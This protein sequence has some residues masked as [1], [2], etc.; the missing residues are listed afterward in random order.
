MTTDCQ[1]QDQGPRP[2]T[3]LVTWLTWSRLETRITIFYIIIII[4]IIIITDLY[5]TFRSEDTEVAYVM[6]G[7][8]NES[9]VSFHLCD[10]I[11]IIK[12]M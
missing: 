11:T 8:T 4:I 7:T 9:T 1:S 10:V 5:S 3:D 12:Q 2:R 6:L